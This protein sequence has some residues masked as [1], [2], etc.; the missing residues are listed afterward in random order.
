M[1][2]I[3][4]RDESQRRIQAREVK[5]KQTINDISVFLAVAIVFITMFHTVVWAGI[6]NGSGQPTIKK[7]EV[8]L[9]NEVTVQYD[10]SYFTD[11]IEEDIDIA[12][13]R[14]SIMQ[15]FLPTDIDLEYQRIEEEKAREE[16]RKRS[17]LN[18]YEWVQHDESGTT[19]SMTD[20]L[21]LYAY[22]LAT[23]NNIDPALIFGMIMVESRGF[24][25]C[26]NS[27]SGAAGLGQFM[28]GTGKLVYEDFLGNGKGSYDH[29]STPYDPYTGI[30]MMITYLN[31]LYTRHGNT[32]TV[33]ESYS[34]NKTYEGTLRYYNRVVSWTGIDIQ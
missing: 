7:Q 3:L 8:T 12:E 30:T 28:A 1:F 26:R 17:I 10:Q 33:L 14:T 11:P 18:Q 5:K 15:E 23:E 19:N 25:S 27:S 2:S 31:Y 13:E 21:V 20:D 9:S 16:E 29:N 4:R 6:I 24:T 32:M 34:G 22:N